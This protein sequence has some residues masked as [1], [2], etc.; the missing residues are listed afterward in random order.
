MIAEPDPGTP[1]RNEGE[2]GAMNP[3]R[4]G[5]FVESLM[6]PRWIRRVVQDIQ[7]SS[8]ARIVLVVIPASPGTGEAP[9][10][11]EKWRGPRHLLYRAFSRMDDRRHARPDDPFQPESLE[12]L[13][14]G[15]EILELR[16]ERDTPGGGADAGD[17]AAIAGRDLDVFLLLGEGTPDVGPAGLARHGV[18]SYCHGDAEVYPGAPAGFWE[19]MESAPVTGSVLRRLRGGGEAPEVLYRSFAS[20][21]W[22]SVRRSRNNYFWKSS[23]FAIRKLSELKDR[24]PEAL[25]PL[26]P[27]EALATRR[28]GERS[29]PPGNLKMSGL[30]LRLAGRLARKKVRDLLGR[31][32]WFLACSRETGI[33]S[34]R[35]SNTCSLQRTGTGPI[36]SRSAGT[37]RPTCS[38][39]RSPA[40]PAGGT[41][42]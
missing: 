29:S 7:A 35:G 23:A 30:M 27:S 10:L 4:V 9:F 28:T 3:L 2:D 17:L 36:P 13:V 33:P 26:E 25:A 16:T 37:G 41:S 21:D 40:T 39:R 32:E 18:W 34:G 6:Q 19:V 42:P 8:A 5:I 12:D 15:C 20:T 22:L 14:G 1:R 31:E 11:G 24:G 38:W